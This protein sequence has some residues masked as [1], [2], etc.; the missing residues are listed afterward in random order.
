MIHLKGSLKE[1]GGMS[2]PA[3]FNCSFIIT[4]GEIMVLCYSSKECKIFIG[5]YS[6]AYINASGDLVECFFPPLIAIIFT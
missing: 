5:K 6:S 1:N 4:V 3:F 2:H